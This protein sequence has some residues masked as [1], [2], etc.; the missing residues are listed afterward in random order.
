M[1]SKNF[2]NFFSNKNLIFLLFYL[3]ILIGFYFDENSLGGAQ[4]DFIHHYKFSQEFNNNFFEV[5]NNFGT[6]DYGTRNSPIFW[7][8]ISFLNKFFSIEIIRILNSTVSLLI[9]FYFYKCLKL[10]FKDQNEITLILLSS[11]IF[12]SPT[13]RSLSIWPYNLVWGL[14]LFIISIYY[15]LKFELSLNN[16][17]KFL[18][19]FKFLFFLILSSYVH[20]SFAIFI[21]FYVYQLYLTFKFSKYSINLLIFCIFLS[22]PCF[23]YIYSTNIISNFYYAEGTD[24]S[25]SQSLNLSNKI[26]IILSMF[27]FFILPILNVKKLVID[28]SLI[29]YKI[30][31]VLLIF[32]SINI[33][34]FNYPYF[35]SGGFGGGFFHKLSNI[36]FGNNIFLYFIFISCLVIIYTIFSKNLDNYILLVALILYNPQ[37]TIY[38]KYFDPLIFI[39]LFTLFNFDLNNH[40]F[41]KKYKFFQLYCLMGVFLIMSL[42]KSYVL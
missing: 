2:E 10:K 35:E 8:I 14:L 32:S 37:F 4:Q 30:L 6:K 27:L 38:N 13:I 5:L 31:I 11:I 15:Y 24:V 39:L 19:S 23:V 1:I 16:S 21:I 17:E 7:I 28:S 18:N 26:V 22:I 25:I 9:A 33:F 42:F 3:S 20:P 40:F 12:L 29:R 34:Y 36:M 41:K